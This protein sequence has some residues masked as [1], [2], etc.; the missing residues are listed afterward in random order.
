MPFPPAHPAA[1][2][3]LRRYCPRFLSFPALVIGS[4]SPDLGYA[5]GDWRVSWLSH[6]FWAGSLEFCLPAGLVLVLV[7]YLVRL[8][9]VRILPVPYRQLFLPLCQRP[10][11]SPCAVIVS[12]LIG[13]WTHI[14]LDSI[15]HPDGWLVG[16]LAILRGSVPWVGARRLGVYQLL[17]AA[18]TFGG[19]AWL[20]F[21]WLS[22]LEKSPAHRGPMRPGRKWCWALLLAS[23]ILLIAEASRGP[24]QVIGVIPAA[25]IAVLLLVG[26]VI[27]AQSK[28]K[29]NAAARR[30]NAETP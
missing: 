24:Y 10:A 30:D 21:S 3:P 28:W 5:F 2:L 16:H 20:G 29:H 17:Y 25:I 11:S 19:V 8:P 13:A 4:L 27:A 6:R 7:F 15:T 26:F 23:G 9:A 18:W 12:L 22:W 1:V 14:F